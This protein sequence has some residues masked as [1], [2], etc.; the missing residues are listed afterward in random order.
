MN[1]LGNADVSN[2]CGW[3]AS[4]SWDDEIYQRGSCGNLFTSVPCHVLTHPIGNDKENTPHNTA[5]V[6]ART[7]TLIGAHLVDGL[8]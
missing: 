1:V 3:A 8:A 6:R 7:K 5:N 2:D 4:S